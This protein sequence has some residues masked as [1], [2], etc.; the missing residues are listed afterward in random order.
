[1]ILSQGAIK[2]MK[3][4]NTI[5]LLLFTTTIFATDY[6]TISIYENLSYGY[7]ISSNEKTYTNAVVP[8]DG[9]TAPEIKLIQKSNG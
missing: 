2:N 7:S 8:P 5:L 1:M 3:I 9:V 4:M 6:K